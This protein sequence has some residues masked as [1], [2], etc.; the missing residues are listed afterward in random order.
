VEDLFPS[1]RRKWNILR[2]EI[3][4]EM[5]IRSNLELIASIF[6]AT[7]FNAI[8]GNSTQMRAISRKFT[9][10]NANYRK[11]QNDRGIAVADA[12]AILRTGLT[13]PDTLLL[14]HGSIRSPLG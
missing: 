11:F 7:Q 13:S 9:K 5:A 10:T 2:K 1:A 14:R 4:Q 6:A 12:Q 8:F 3:N